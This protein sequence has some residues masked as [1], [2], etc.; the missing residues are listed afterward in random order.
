MGC[1]RQ[2]GGGGG[3]GLPASNNFREMLGAKAAALQSKGQS[4]RRTI[5]QNP[6]TVASH[7]TTALRGCAVECEDEGLDEE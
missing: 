5:R 2:R 7:V 4:T 1:C 6:P 3:G